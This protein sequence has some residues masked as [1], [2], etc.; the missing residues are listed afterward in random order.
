MRVRFFFFFWHAHFQMRDV[1]REYFS[2]R[3]H[4]G[5]DQPSPDRRADQMRLDPHVAHSEH[6]T[7]IPVPTAY[8]GVFA[9]YQCLAAL[10][11]PRHFREH[12]AHHERLRGE[13]RHRVI[14]NGIG[15]DCSFTIR[16]RV[17]AISRFRTRR[18]ESACV[19]IVNDHRCV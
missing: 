17:S 12:D 3:R 11:R 4:P 13:Q 6:E 8:H 16:G 18:A 15:S 10:F 5:S 1:R 7:Q 2:F 14:T 19:R 9:E